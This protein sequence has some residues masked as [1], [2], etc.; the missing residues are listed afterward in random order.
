[1]MPPPQL[2]VIWT[3]DAAHEKG[4]VGCGKKPSVVGFQGQESVTEKG[5]GCKNEEVD[6]VKG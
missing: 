6:D 4:K 1:M 5:K 3:M 2:T